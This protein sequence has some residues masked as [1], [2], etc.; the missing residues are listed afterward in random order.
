MICHYTQCCVARTADL[1]ACCT[2]LGCEAAAEAR[3]SI[4]AA[5]AAA[6]DGDRARS[7]GV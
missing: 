5:M 4:R 7:E 6:W 2:A 1:T 3:S